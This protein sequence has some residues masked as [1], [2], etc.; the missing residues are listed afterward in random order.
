KVRKEPPATRAKQP[1]AKGVK[2]PARKRL[3]QPIQKVGESSSV[4]LTS[5]VDSGARHTRDR[6]IDASVRREKQVAQVMQP[7]H[8]SESS[9]PFDD[10]D[11]DHGFEQELEAEFALEDED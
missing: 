7:V 10:E 9:R 5:D 6:C 1:A 3:A 11:V 2:K 4:Y 8:E